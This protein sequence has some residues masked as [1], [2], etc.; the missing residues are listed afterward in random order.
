MTCLLASAKN[1]NG[2]VYACS[3]DT[4]TGFNLRR[5]VAEVKV[6]MTVRVKT[7]VD[8]RNQV[9][10]GHTYVSSSSSDATKKFF[11]STKAW[12]RG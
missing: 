10:E 2:S 11:S 9:S 3:C 5:C 1:G 12:A 6:A 4:D 8:S 7:R